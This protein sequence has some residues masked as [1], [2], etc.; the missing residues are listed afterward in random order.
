[1]HQEKYQRVYEILFGTTQPPAHTHS[2]TAAVTAP[3]YDAQGCTT[4]TCACGDSYVD[5]FVEK[6]SR[7]P[8][9]NNPAQPPAQQAWWEKLPSFVQWLLRIFLFGFIWMR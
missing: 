5:S 9:D 4:H 7:P 1:M 3:T 6:L 2:Y 8:E